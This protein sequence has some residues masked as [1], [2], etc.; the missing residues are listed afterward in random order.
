MKKNSSNNKDIAFFD[1]DGTITTKD[2][3]IDFLKYTKGNINFFKG[4]IILSPLIIS[5]YLKKI[6][7]Q[8]LKEAFINYYFNNLKIDQFMTIANDYS[9]K[10][11]IKIINPEALKKIKW[12]QNKG[13]E[14]IVVTASLEY[15]IENWCNE[16]NLKLIGTKIEVKNNR[17]TGKIQ[18]KNCS[19]IEKVKRIKTMYDLKNY[20]II[21][22]YGNGSG[23]IEMLKISDKKFY[24]QF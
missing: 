7:S 4:I 14:V 23:D 8:K 15:W 18:G 20:N 16:M 21:Y 2:S 24:R 13:D 6:S 9:K 3:F 12:H 19:G 22:A 1:F 17:L 11:I 5:F 10:R